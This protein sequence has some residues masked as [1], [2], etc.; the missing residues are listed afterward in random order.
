MNNST[1]FAVRDLIKSY[2]QG[3]GQLD[4]LK[5][6]SFELKAGQM[7]ALVGSSGSG[8][9]TLLHI[10][11][12]LDHPTSGQV[13]LEGQSCWDE[14]DATRTQLRRDAIGFVYQ[15]HHLLPE[16]TAAENIMLPQVLAGQS[17]ENAHVRAMELLASLNLTDRSH[18]RPSQLSG[19]EQ[20]RVAVL[21]ALANKPK[22][23]L[24]D[25]PTGNLDEETA[26]KVF[27]EMM[28]L[29]RAHGVTA[30]IATHDMS[31]AQKM[32]RIIQLKGGRVVTD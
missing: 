29:V 16:F 18:H 12:L 27:H 14:S 24:A 20:Q 6:I 4:V 25:E 1:V 32:D 30:L 10:A 7:T 19:G 13:L 22:L 26:H 28:T 9:S 3:E 11:G 21:R 15:F 5:G 31:L 17:W 23:L 8:K 2:A